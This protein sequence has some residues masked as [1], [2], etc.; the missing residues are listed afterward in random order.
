[1]KIKVCTGKNCK[2]KFSEYIVQRL[3][4]DVN[5]FNLENVEVEEVMCQ[6][7]CE[8][9]PIV[10]IDKNMLT[11]STPIKASEMLFKR[12]NWIKTNNKK[13][14]KERNYEDEDN[15]NIKEVLF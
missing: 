4:N 15:V 14:K 9:W 1:M 8:E 12:L 13:Q 3:Q 7:K 10:R 2:N 6:W 5:R 11:K